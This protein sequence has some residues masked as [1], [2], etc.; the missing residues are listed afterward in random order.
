MFFEKE[1]VRVVRPRKMAIAI[2]ISE[3]K[4]ATR[5]KRGRGE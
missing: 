5:R 1:E 4:A 2:G 3:G